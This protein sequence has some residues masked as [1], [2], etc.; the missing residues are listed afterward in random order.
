VAF[1]KVPLGCLLVVVLTAQAA[2]T[3]PPAS[4]PET[5]TSTQKQAL[6]EERDRLW[7]RA[8]ALRK[9]RDLPGAMTLAE[10]VLTIERRVF[11]DTN[12]EVA[13]TFLFLAWCLEQRGD[14]AAA[15]GR[16][17]GL[18]AI[19]A[20]LH[21]A[22]N[23]QG[24]YARFKV[25]QLVRV[26]AMPGEDRQKLAAA[27]RQHARA[28]DLDDE[29]H[30]REAIPLA[31][32]AASIRRGILG[33]EDADTA[34]SLSLLGM[35][36]LDVGDYLRAEAPWR[37]ALDVRRR[38]FGA[39]HPATA[40]SLNDLGMLET[41]LGKYAEADALLKEALALN[42]STFGNGVPTSRSLNRLGQNYQS[43]GDY[44]RAEPLM[45]EAL[46]LRRN[47]F[48]ESH[49]ETAIMLGNL[50]LLYTDMGEYARAEALWQQA[51]A[52]DRK[53]L[54]PEHPNTARDVDSLGVVYRKQGNYVEAASFH[55]Q[56]LAVRQK[57]FGAENILTSD[58]L[59]NLANA[60]EMLGDYARAEPLYQRSLTITRKL[61]G[62]EHPETATILANL[63]ILYQSLGEYARAESVCRQALDITR[64]NQSEDPPR[65]A[66]MLAVLG[67]VYSDS[68][69]YPRAERLY[70]ESLEIHRKVL[71]ENHVDTAQSLLRLGTAYR[72]LGDYGR[73]RPLLEQALEIDRKVL[74]SEHPN[75]AR[76]I[77]NLASLHRSLGE[78]A[79][80]ESVFRQALVITRKQ[81]ALVAIVQSERQQLASARALRYQLDG[82]LSLV[83]DTQAFAPV[84]WEQAL[85]WKGA[86]LGHQRALRAS[87]TDPEMRAMFADLQSTASRLATLALGVPSRDQADAWHRQVTELSARKEQLEAD[88]ARKSARFRMALD[89]PTAA[90]LRRALPARTVLIDF[91]EY[92]HTPAKP[93]GADNGGRGEARL[94][95]F[96][97]R[98]DREVRLIALGP[99]AP[100]AAA[101][102]V[103]RT[104]LGSGEEASAAG[105]QLRK[106]IWAPIQ[107]ELEDVTPDE[108]LVS[109]DGVLG[110][111]PL[112]ALPGRAPGTYLLEDWPI[113]TL[114]APQMLLDLQASD[115]R[116]RPDGNV[117][118]LGNVNYDGRDAAVQ[119]PRPFPS[120]RAAREDDTHF[121]T[122]EGT[123]GELATI[124]KLYRDTFGA[125]GITS[126]GGTLATKD[127][128]RREAQRH[129][130]VHF[131]THGFFAAERFKSALGRSEHQTTADMDLRGDQSV[132]GYHPG[133]LSG[134]ALSGANVPTPD[135][136]GI[137]TAEEV[138]TLD[139]SA[140]QLAVLS[141]CE[142]GLGQVAGG[143]GLLGLQRAFHA[144]GARTVIATLWKVDDV[145]TRDI[146]E[147]FYDNI[148]NKNM[149]KLAALREA[150]IW[151]LRS[152]GA[153]GL[154]VAGRKPLDSQLPPYFWGAFV[155]SGDWR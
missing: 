40:E 33:L 59:N 50:G 9:Q 43:L 94:I 75:T 148:W 60:Y 93:A 124:E 149:G 96:V 6:I 140:V 114:P 117:L 128:V 147:R 130:Y 58:S 61:F 88:L 24:A 110:Q 134:L 7:D 57:I 145:A 83:A 142:T 16:Y 13:G 97:I 55:Q 51:L 21:G 150:Q 15:R 12:E 47:A 41:F 92:Q 54:G 11:G 79:Q 69:D 25:V 98:P 42:R 123:R 131:A 112:G 68:G 18:A 103:W 20:A 104:G 100:V 80:A 14:F 116:P 27:S 52:I 26:A 138:G 143:E 35:V 144:A 46:T 125:A 77:Y 102:A 113:A 119:A 67:N 31:E 34:G 4:P 141:A 10:E 23:W 153:R 17:E 1:V 70:R 81:L 122:L 72:A 108:I 118:L 32:E 136:D 53:A 49:M 73:A 62:P 133:L 76:A 107:A 85:A 152:R 56:A 28:S 36:H 65:L 101:I 87:S 29:G 82:Y 38:I 106:M 127:A 45:Q 2:P 95:A 90:A 151:M 139:L 135:D 22:D 120:L 121:S 126:L 111:V 64:R 30:A 132:A 84:A 39:K 44:S 154:T 99:V 155:L 5:L 105:Q 86:A 74:G 8:E 129:L 146:M 66:Y 89:V 78:V 91:L 48:G 71:G 137:L 37:E 63:G 19:H 3:R 115:S 109:P